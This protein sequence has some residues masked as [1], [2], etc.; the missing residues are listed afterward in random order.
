[1][2]LFNFDK[3][4]RHL[5]K[6]KVLKKAIQVIDLPERN[7]SK[8]VYQGLIR[9]IVS[10]QLS[11]KAAETIHGRFINLFES[12]YPHAELL[13]ALE[14]TQLRSVGLSGQ[15]TKYVKNVASFFIE[16]DLFDKDWSEES[17]QQIISLLTE[18]KGVGQ[19]TVEM[20]LMFVLSRE[21]ILP[22]LDL[23]IQQGIQQLYGITAEKKE[24][25][26]KMKEIAE[27]WRPYRSIAC[28]YLWAIKDLKTE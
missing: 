27:P 4:I 11:V 12:N 10:Q 14:D 28:L 6:D 17:D 21:D 3:A 26:A 13:L 7:P 15:K 18:I 19:W 20:I 16:H 5:S 23:G 24:L 8:D 1:M 22:V 25:Y 9:S 2:E